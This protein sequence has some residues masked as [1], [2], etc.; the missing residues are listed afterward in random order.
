MKKVG[1]PATPLEPAESRSSPPGAVA[2]A[3]EPGAGVGVER[4]GQEALS[5]E[6]G[7]PV[8]AAGD[9]HPADGDGGRGVR[10]GRVGGTEQ[11]DP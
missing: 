5:G 1:V 7:A 11:H 3:V 9:A 10:E 4:V 2:A 8:V 6:V